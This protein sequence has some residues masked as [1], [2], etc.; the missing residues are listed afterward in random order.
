MYYVFR[1]SRHSSR[2]SAS[3]RWHSAFTDHRIQRRP[4][5]QTD[6]PADAGLTAWRDPSPDLQKRNLGIAYVEIGLQRRSPDFLLQGYR[7]LTEVQ[8]QFANDS[9]VFRWI[10]QALLIGKQQSEAAIALERA[11][12]LDP[13]SAIAEASAAAPYL[14]QGDADRAMAHLERAVT[15]DPMDLPTA[16]ALIDLYQK[17]GK[18]AEAAELSG[19]IKLLKRSLPSLLLI[20]PWQPVTERN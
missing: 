5:T 3:T 12:K 19:K 2:N 1:I 8:Q 15:L 13:G 11:L 10:G 14:Q 20:L 9:E 4:Q 16:I 17:Q 7:T 18:R 6:L